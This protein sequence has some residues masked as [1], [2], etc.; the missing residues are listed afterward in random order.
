LNLLDANV[1]R[2]DRATPVPN[3]VLVAIL[4]RF[5]VMNQGQVEKFMQLEHVKERVVNEPQ[6]RCGAEEATNYCQLAVELIA[7]LKSH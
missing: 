7:A 3:G 1:A 4:C 6:M 5:G 2:S